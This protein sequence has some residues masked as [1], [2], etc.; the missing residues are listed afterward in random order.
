[1]DRPTW[2]TNERYWRKNCREVVQCCRDLL[3]GRL[4]VIE[5]AR[6]LRELAFR[7]RAEDDPEFVL[8]RF[9]DSGSDAPP[10]GPRRNWSAS[11][12]EREDPQIAAFEAKWRSKGPPKNNFP[13]CVAVLEH[14]A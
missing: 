3:E 6:L 13:G 1:M 5:T 4:G 2:V 12:L 7:V 8:F 10:V 14:T 11:T 9:L